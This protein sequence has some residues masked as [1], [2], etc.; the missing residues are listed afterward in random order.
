MKKI[1]LLSLFVFLTIGCATSTSKWQNI[2][3]HAQNSTNESPE[4]GTLETEELEF[5]VIVT[6]FREVVYNPF[7]QFEQEDPTF[8]AV[9]VTCRNQTGETLVLGLNPIQV[10]GPSQTLA[11]ELPL[12]H[13]MY[14]LYGGRLREAT[15]LE[16][17]AE[18][19]EPVPVG[20]TFPG[21]VLSGIVAGL[22][23]AESASIVGEMYQKEA[24]QY[25]LYYHSFDS[26]SLPGGVATSWTQYYPYT[27][28][29]IQVMLQGQKVEEGVIF[30]LP[31][32]PPRL[33]PSPP[34]STSLT[35]KVIGI[36]VG[37]CILGLVSLII[38]ATY[39]K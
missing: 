12:E 4:I 22:R 29:P 6:E 23:A 9:S 1:S 25:Q 17:L 38:I 30:A 39:V 10:I 21:A 18:L 32:P 19:S 28:G 16:R 33:P 34:Q 8:I 31:P 37:S 36:I 7:T 24:S 11:R 15:Q 5:N 2:L 20:S 27:V 26:A 14:K 3:W 13:V 35:D